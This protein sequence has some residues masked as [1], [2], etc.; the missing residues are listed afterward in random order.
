MHNILTEH[1]QCP[2][3]G[4]ESFLVENT[5]ST[6]MNWATITVNGEIVYQDPNTY[7]SACHC[8]KCGQLFHIIEKEGIKTKVI[9]E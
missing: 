5:T 3:C 9:P 2:Y 8:L 6:L 1:I 7:T 4:S